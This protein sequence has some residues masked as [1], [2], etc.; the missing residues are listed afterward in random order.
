[1]HQIIEDEGDYNILYQLPY[2][3]YSAIISTAI[4]RIMLS[5]LVLTEKGVLEVK[6]ELTKFSA[7]EKKKKVLRCCIIKFSIFFALN[8]IL[9]V[10]FW[11]Y[12]TCF[13]ALYE[14]TQIDLII[15]SV[16]SF[17]ISLIYPFVINIIPAVFRLDSLK[18]N[19]NENEKTK[20]K[21]KINKKKSKKIENKP[22]I[23]KEG[24]YVYK[25]SKWLQVL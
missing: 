9:L 19:K 17:A 4:L 11:Y 1:M 3:T 2:I 22:K 13:N 7:E 20:G 10:A 5:G 15:N 25:V 23:N 21:K 8:L 14:N 18:G 6:N 24:E 16:I 12:V